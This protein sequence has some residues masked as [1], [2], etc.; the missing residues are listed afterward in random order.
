MGNVR[1]TVFRPD[2]VQKNTSAVKSTYQILKLPRK[3]SCC[4]KCTEL[5]HDRMYGVPCFYL[6]ET[7]IKRDFP[8]CGRSS[9]T[10]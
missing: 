8:E 4:Y 1:E 3:Q 6:A 10:D 2:G 9:L 5:L 7:A